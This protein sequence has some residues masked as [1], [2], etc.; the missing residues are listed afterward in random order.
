DG[1]G[2]GRIHRRVV[3]VGV[4]EVTL[5]GVDHVA[6]QPLER[7]GQ[8]PLVADLAADPL[9]ALGV[10]AAAG[11]GAHARGDQVAFVVGAHDD[12]DHAR[13]RVRTVDGRGAAGQ[14]LDALDGRGRD[15]VEVHRVRLAVVGQR[16]VGGAA[17]V[18]QHQLV[19]RAEATQVEE[20]GVRGEAVLGQ[21]V[22]HRT[23]ELGQGVQRVVDGAEALLLKVLGGD[24]GH[25]GGAFDLRALDAR[26]GR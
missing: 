24:D 22:L 21:L 11:G 19:T 4:H 25:R 14:D 8:A 18:D 7:V 6:L 2:V 16:V 15:R 10:A 1:G 3:A 20:A 5:R 23:G 17:A 9:Q 12:V 13:D 26:T